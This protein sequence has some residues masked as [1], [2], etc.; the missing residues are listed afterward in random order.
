MKTKSSTFSSLQGESSDQKLRQARPEV[1]QSLW[2][3][4][5]PVLSDLADPLVVRQASSE[6]HTPIGCPTSFVGPGPT[7][8]VG[9]GRSIGC[10]TSFVGM[11]YSHWLSD[12]LCWNGLL[13]LIL[14]PIGH[15]WSTCSR[16][17]IQLKKICNCG[18]T[19]PTRH[20]IGTVSF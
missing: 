1:R 9:P 2:D 17:N 6:R 20:H 14:R 10:P 3:L 5:R 8:L 4:V 16:R 18:N 7:S 19:R 11:A 15:I 13:F 12:E